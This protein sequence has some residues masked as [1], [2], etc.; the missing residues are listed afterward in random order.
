MPASP[1]S[2]HH[3]RIHAVLTRVHMRGVGDLLEKFPHQLSG[4]QLQRIV[5]ARA[6]VLGPKFI[7]ADE[8]V[9]ML[10]V[11]VRAGI[12][13]LMREI[14]REPRP[15]RGLHLARSRAG[16]LRRAPHAGDVSR[17]H[18]GGRADRA[19]GLGA[20]AS[21]HQGAGRRGADPARRP[22]PR[23]AADPRQRAGRAQPAVRLPL[24]RPLPARGRR[25]AARRC[26]RCAKS[27]RGTGR[28]VIWCRRARSNQSA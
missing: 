2:E 23:A 21:L 10:D 9:S 1:R 13:N 17:D 27:R 11:S 15:H 5:L 24:P 19:R 25:A 26:R 3:D 7:V 4:G 8:P 16:A 18:R 6:L 20:A 28:R 22:V 14:Q 12:L